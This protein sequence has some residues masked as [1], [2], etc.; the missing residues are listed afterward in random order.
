[1]TPSMEY[2]DRLTGRASVKSRIKRKGETV[3]PPESED[4]A[5][6]S[7]GSGV[8]PFTSCQKKTKLWGKCD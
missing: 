3:I 7:E 2:S 5:H 1:M 4:M 6:T 8:C